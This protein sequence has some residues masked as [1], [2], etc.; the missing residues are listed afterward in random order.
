M[1]KLTTLLGSITG[2]SSPLAGRL[3]LG[4]L[5]FA[6]VFTMVLAVVMLV[7]D[8]AN[9]GAVYL[10]LINFNLI[11]IALFMVV[12]GRRFMMLFLERKKGL[13]GARLQVRLL[14]IFGFLAVVPALIVSIFSV[15]FLNLGIEAWFSSRVT[16]ALDNSL[17]VAQAYL[18]STAT[19]SWLKLA[20]LP[21]TRTST[22][23]PSSS[24]LK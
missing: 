16:K 10:A 12:M 13:V 4:S 9:S 1:L 15:V 8:S 24:T 23:P 11:L 20:P 5:G 3:L 14:A 22:R 18:E 7:S 21:T 6:A 2:A 19:C 17:E